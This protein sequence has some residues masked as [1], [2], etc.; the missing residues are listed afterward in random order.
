MKNFTRLIT[1]IMCAIAMMITT[2][3]QAFQ[4]DCLNFDLFLVDNPLGNSQ[5]VSTMYG[6]DL[7]S[8]SAVL[9][10]I[11]T[12]DFRF[13]IAYNNQ[14]D[15]IY[16]VK[17]DGSGFETI[18]AANG[19][20]V[21]FTAFE[22]SL[23]ATPTAVYYDGTLYIGSQ[24]QNNIV[25][26]DFDT[27]SY[28]V[29]AINVP[30]SGGDLVEKDGRLYLATRA[31]NLLYEV[32]SGSC[33][34]AVSI[35]NKVTG[36]SITADNTILMSNRDATALNEIDL[37]GSIIMT[38]PVYLNNEVFT[39]RNGDMAGGC[40]LSSASNPDDLCEDYQMFYSDIQGAN[41]NIYGVSLN[42]DDADL[43]LLTNV[44]GKNH[45]SY[46]TTNGNIYAVDEAG[47]TLT[48]IT[49]SGDK[50]SI[51]LA[52][53]LDKVV[54]NVYRDGKLYLGS[55]TL[56]ILLEVNISTGDYVVIGSDLPIGGGDLVFRGTDLFLATRE[57][58]RILQID[59]DTNTYTEVANIAAKVSGLAL[60]NSGEYLMS[61][62]NTTE[63]QLL[64]SDGTYIKTYN[65]MVNGNPLALRSGDLAAGCAGDG[66]TDPNA[67]NTELVNGGFELENDLSGSWDY[68]PQDQVPGWSTTSA[69][70]TIEIQA[71]MGTSDMIP[72]NSG[73][74]HFELNGD[75]LNTLYQ[76]FCT[77]PGTN[78]EVKFSHKKRRS[79]GTDEMTLYVGDDLETIETTTAIPVFSLDV[80]EWETKTFVFDIPEG[81]DYT[82]IYFKAVSGS[83]PTV[84]NL[85]D[86]IS[87]ESTFQSPTDLEDYFATLSTIEQE[88]LV[89]EISM[90]PV[91]ANDRLN[92]KLNSQVGGSVSY[93]IVSIM[94]QSFNRGTVETYSGRTE[95][96]ANI[97]SLADGTYFFVVN[98][99]GN[100]TTKQFVKV[101]R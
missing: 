25:A 97:S 75:G 48:T 14:E 59:T 36:V 3:V 55:D 7:S 12:R 37:D 26:Y 8:G 45:I 40:N 68:V 56:D 58:N 24:G 88:A 90:Y 19:A 51:A 57:G 66:S 67:C 16:V 63:F 22:N 99:N 27:A 33:T 100:T 64:S 84:G 53:G 91:P 30:V 98:L 89:S 46:D 54:T 72:S 77:T 101:S 96:T 86:D 87:V 60:T 6:V 50:S 18:D 35:P 31:G 28:F 43:T 47:T 42:G 70:G 85:M 95:I 39:L 79:S 41:S 92:I 69:P 73:D 78:L 5:E 62:A 44:I 21:R 61:N 20:T 15:L 94:G 80:D 11:M 81:Q 32:I 2:D 10:E 38:Y 34:D 52:S 9:N 4:S 74:F 1:T 93:E 29:F 65:V 76:G 71:N 17:N 49:S 13:H 82:Y 23:G 83:G